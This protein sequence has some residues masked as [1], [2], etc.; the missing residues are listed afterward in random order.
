MIGDDEIAKATVASES[1]P[2][3]DLRG[4]SRNLTLLGIIQQGLSTGSR[5]LIILLQKMIIAFVLM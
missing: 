2:S 4:S 5:N 1:E 3:T